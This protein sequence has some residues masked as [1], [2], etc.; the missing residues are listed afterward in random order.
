M[1]HSSLSTAANMCCMRIMRSLNSLH[2]SRT[3]ACKALVELHPLTAKPVESR[4]P[5]TPRIWD[6]TAAVLPRSAIEDANLVATPALDCE[7]EPAVKVPSTAPPRETVR[8]RFSEQALPI[9]SSPEPQEEAPKAC[10]AWTHSKTSPETTKEFHSS[11][12][13]CF[14]RFCRCVRSAM[15]SPAK[16][17]P[18]VTAEPIPSPTPTGG[19]ANSSTADAIPR[20]ALAVLPTFT[21][22]H[23]LVKLLSNAFN[24][25][26]VSRCTSTSAW[27][28]ATSRLVVQM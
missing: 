12:E 17:R 11:L 6:A 8:W 9:W 7:T 21:P 2:L 16:V 26:S 27:A 22:S 15:E 28:A 24:P 14:L 1:G 3:E 5:A 20:P 13:I 25:F 19:A 4:A 23:W 18:P 10:L